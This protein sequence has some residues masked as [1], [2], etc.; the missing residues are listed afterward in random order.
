VRSELPLEAISAQ[1]KTQKEFGKHSRNTLI[2][3]RYLKYNVIYKKRDIVF[4][5]MSV[6]ERKRGR[7]GV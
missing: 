4:I 1:D 5:D 6:S 7:V 2:E 3:F